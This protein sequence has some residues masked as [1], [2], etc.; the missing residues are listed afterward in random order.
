MIRHIT[1]TMLA[2]LNLS[3][4]SQAHDEEV[5][6]SQEESQITQEQE[7]TTPQDPQQENKTVSTNQ[8]LEW[9]NAV[10]QLPEED[11]QFFIKLIDQSLSL[12]AVTQVVERG[13]LQ[14]VWRD[15]NLTDK[16]VRDPYGLISVMGKELNFWDAIDAHL[17][18]STWHV[19]HLADWFRELI[20][21]RTHNKA[22]LSAQEEYL[23]FTEQWS[24]K[25][26]RCRQMLQ[27][28][29]NSKN[30]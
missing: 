5:M 18:K 29:L 2:L 8:C 6:P 16:E 9:C 1:I 26:R 14:I 17:C 21:G 11:I 10:T 13:I 25:A 24:L 30:K 7:P 3:Q 28:C 19:R 27:D 15:E 22:L 4:L 12:I 23:P 20:L